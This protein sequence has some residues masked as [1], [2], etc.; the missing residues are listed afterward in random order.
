M[1]CHKK[2]GWPMGVNKS[3]GGEYPLTTNEEWEKE[4]KCGCKTPM[5]GVCV[6]GTVVAIFAANP[7]QG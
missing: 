4:K 7:S 2:T 5:T 3:H 6:D 1:I